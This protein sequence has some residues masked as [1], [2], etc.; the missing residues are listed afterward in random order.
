MFST[1][2]DGLLHFSHPPMVLIIF[3]LGWVYYDKPLFFYAA[4]LSC[5]SILINVALKGTFKVPLPP[6]LH[7]GYAFP[8]GHMQFATVFYG[9]LFYHI[10]NRALRLA[11]PLLLVCLSIGMMQHH[12]H[13]LT[14]I[15][16]G[17]VTG[18]LLI[19]LFLWTLKNYEQRIFAI[20]FV[21]SFFVMGYN[22][23]I[24]P[25]IPPHTWYAW[26]MLAVL[27]VTHYFFLKGPFLFQQSLGNEIVGDRE[28]HPGK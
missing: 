11:I 22:F 26:A 3:I 15:L 6:E 25:T 19:R 16:A 8:S 2:I 21:L 7:S 24:Y 12:Y 1:A 5:M 20:F 9:W 10:P 28:I 23:M 17:F 27:I 18:V 14:E 4:C 13:T